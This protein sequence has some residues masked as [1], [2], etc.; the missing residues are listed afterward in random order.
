MAKLTI[1]CGKICGFLNGAN[2]QWIEEQSV[3]YATKGN[4]W[5]GFDN[6]HSIELKVNT[7]VPPPSTNTTLTPILPALTTASHPHVNQTTTTT[8]PVVPGGTF[9]AGKPDGLYKN[10]EN[11]N[12]FYQCSN[13]STHIQLCPAKL[14]YNDSCKNPLLKTLLAVGGWTFGSAKFSGM[15]ATPANRGA[16][17][18]SSISTLR[19][20][21]FDGLDLDW[22]YPGHEEV[23]RKTNTDLHCCARN[24]WRLLAAEGAATGRPRLMLTA[25]VAAGK[26]DFAMKYWRD[27]GA[28]AAK[29][30]LGPGDVGAPADGPATDGPYTKAQGMWSYYEICTF[31]QQASV[32]WI[33]S[34]Q[35]PYATRGAEWVGYDNKDSAARKYVRDEGFGGAFVWALDLD[36]FTGQFCAQGNFSLISQLRS[37]LDSD[38][39]PLPPIFMD[40]MMKESPAEAATRAPTSANFCSGKAG[41]LYAKADAPGSFYSCANGLTWDPELPSGFGLPREL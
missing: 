38:P 7:Y 17:I 21:G 15:V 6:K 35:V 19:R 1:L 5:V 3:P 34:Q 37:V 30:N 18:Q 22:E 25:A 40:D 33:D 28:P 2:V 20:H 27:Q 39:L 23:P 11:P 12:S 14:V 32:Q 29:L 13:G 36:D 24:C 4:E 41:G 9:C 16:F 26:S 31:I 8:T 10:E